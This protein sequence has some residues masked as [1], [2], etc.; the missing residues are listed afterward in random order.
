MSERQSAMSVV[1]QNI[2]KNFGSFTAINGL[3]LRIEEGEFFS[4]LG[5]SG[6]GK[7]TLLRMIGGFEVCDS[8][9]ILVR[10]EDVAKVAPHRRRTKIIFQNLALFPHL[11]VYENLAF[12]LRARNTPHR[13]IAA[14]IEETLA[15]VHLDEMARRDINQLSGGQRQRVAIARALINKPDILLLDEPLGALDLKLRI[16]MQHELRRLQRELKSTFIFVTHDQ[17]E[18]MAMSDRIAV[19]NRGELLQV[20]TPGEIYER[21]TSRFV[22]EFVGNTNLLDGI[23]DKDGGGS[24]YAVRIGRLVATGQSEHALAVGQAVVL[25]LRYEKLH[26]SD[27]EAV[28]VDTNEVSF[29]RATVT[30]KSYLGAMLQYEIAT[31][32]GM[33]LTA[34]LANRADTQAIQIGQVV[35]AS[36]AH[37]SIRILPS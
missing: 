19:M 8:G 22:A 2:S 18:A 35:S 7:T 3:S 1:I 10:N 12:G 21:P 6:C 32:H 9:H 17:T 36:C 24:T 37:D 15:L 26:L 4:L 16:Q 5:P 31:E 11:D 28:P 25:S 23:V 13:E 33:K 34:E 20:G 29:G 27:N 14:R 30:A